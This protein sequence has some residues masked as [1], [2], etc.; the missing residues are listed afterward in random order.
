MTF[1][2]HSPKRDLNWWNLTEARASE[3]SSCPARS[4]ES[5][6]LCATSGNQTIAAP[7][8]AMKRTCGL[9]RPSFRDM[10]EPVK[11]LETADVGMLTDLVPPYPTP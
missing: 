10:L 11:P 1:P 7:C 2:F 6:S 4:P 8:A 9:V 3:L 5:S